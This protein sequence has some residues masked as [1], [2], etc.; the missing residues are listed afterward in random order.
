MTIL[1]PI[2]VVKPEELTST[3]TDSGWQVVVSDDPINLIT[4]VCLVFQKVLFLDKATAMKYTMTVHEKGRCA[5]FFGERDICKA[6][7]EQL[8]SYQLWTHVE[9]VS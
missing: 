8:M 1:A 3:E 4:F 6:K 5:V 7:A 9:K 2:E